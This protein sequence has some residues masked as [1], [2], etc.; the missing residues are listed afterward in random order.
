MGNLKIGCSSYSFLNLDLHQILNWLN[1]VGLKWIDIGPPIFDL[2]NRQSWERIRNVCQEYS[3]KPCILTINSENLW[4]SSPTSEGLF[5]SNLLK[6]AIDAAVYTKSYRIGLVVNKLPDGQSKKDAFLGLVTSLNKAKN[7]C[8]E[9][10]VDLLIEVHVRGPLT[11]L[12]EAIDLKEKVPS[13]HIGFTLDTSLLV[14]QEIDF[15]EACRSLKDR[16]LNVHIRDLTN[17]D[18]F[19]IPGRG[20][21]DFKRCLKILSKIG[22][23]KP[24]IIELFKTEENYKI[25]LQDAIRETKLFLEKIWND[26]EKQKI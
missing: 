16:P 24:L 26:I 2:C 5:E 20:S 4:S 1:S 23:D 7:Y 9:K 17:H 10:G 8:K 18:F 6:K 19:G 22:Y 13:P 15:V 25:S 21:I 3:V 12:K 14:Y 11:T